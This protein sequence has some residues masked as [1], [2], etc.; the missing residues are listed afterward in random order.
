MFDTIDGSNVSNQA[1]VISASSEDYGNGWF[2]YKVTYTF[3]NT[4]NN[5]Y[6]YAGLRLYKRDASGNPTSWDATGETTGI[7]VYGTQ[8]ELGSHATSYIPTDNNIGGVTRAADDL[9]IDGSD[10]TNVYNTVEGTVYVEYEPRVLGTINTALEF[11][12]GSTDNRIFSLAFGAY[13]CYIVD[14]GVNQAVLDGGTNTAGVLNRLAF[15]YEANN[16]QAS[17]DGGAVV[18]DTSA[19]IPTVDRLILGNQTVANTRHLNGHIK[20]VIYWPYHSDNL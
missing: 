12:D 11:S 17:L 15:S 7:L 2:R 19:S 4:I 8:F 1:N 14:G 6:L 10:F 20:R 5:N 13:H 18:N 3:Q 16:I 9:V